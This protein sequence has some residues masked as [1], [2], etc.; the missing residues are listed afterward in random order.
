MRELQQ[1]QTL[2]RALKTIKV[3]YITKLCLSKDR[4]FLTTQITAFKK[5]QINKNMGTGFDPIG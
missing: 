5:V 2:Y 4:C 3:R 1:K